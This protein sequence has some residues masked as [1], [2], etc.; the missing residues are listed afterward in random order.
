MKDDLSWNVRDQNVGECVR[1]VVCF[2]YEFVAGRARALSRTDAAGN[3]LNIH[4]PWLSD[5]GI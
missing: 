2:K 4:V 5:V 1:G 3:A